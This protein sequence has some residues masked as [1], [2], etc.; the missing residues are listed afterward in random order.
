MDVIIPTRN[1]H[2]HL[3]RIIGVLRTLRT[4][5]QI[6]VVDNASAPNVSTRIKRLCKQHDA[7]K[8]HFC[9]LPGKG[10]AIREA[11]THVT[12]DALFLDADIENLTAEMVAALIDK[13]QEGHDLVKAAFTRANGQSN[14][15][16]VLEHIHHVLPGLRLRKPT[17]GIF[18]VKKSVLDRIHIPNDWSVDL[19]IAVQAHKLGCSI[20]EVDIGEL[21]DKPRT[22]ESLSQSKHCLL[23]ELEALT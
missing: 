11:L 20:A 14:S 6:H 17:G 10:N 21:V 18:C 19:S 9:P 7:C 8:Y 1:D 13:F 15:S 16:F 23:K 4:I 3:N 2:K 22:T 12:D 5:H